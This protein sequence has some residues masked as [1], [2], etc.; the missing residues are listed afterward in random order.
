MVGTRKLMPTMGYRMKPR[1]GNLKI[2]PLKI[3]KNLARWAKPFI[4]RYLCFLL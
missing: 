4:L 3:A 1:R 2:Y